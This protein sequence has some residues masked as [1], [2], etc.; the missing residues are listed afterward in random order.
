MTTDDK[1]RDGKTTY[2]IFTE[3]LKKSQH[4]HL[5][6][7][8]HMNILEVKKIPFVQSRMINQNNFSSSPLGKAF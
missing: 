1:T 3:K 7:L 8:H 6:K 4:Y 2:T 5:D